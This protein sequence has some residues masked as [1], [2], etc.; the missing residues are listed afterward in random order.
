MHFLTNKNLHDLIKN[1]LLIDLLI[2]I[3]ENKITENNLMV[4]LYLRNIDKK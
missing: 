1:S 4:L 3:Q 2:Y